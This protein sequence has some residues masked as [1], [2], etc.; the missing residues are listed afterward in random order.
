MWALA[1]SKPVIFTDWHCYQDKVGLERDAC[2]LANK[3]FDPSIQLC[4][5]S[6][7][8]DFTTVFVSAKICRFTFAKNLLKIAHRSFSLNFFKVIK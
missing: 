1:N 5:F 6:F 8:F 2:G 4:Q 7:L 3:P